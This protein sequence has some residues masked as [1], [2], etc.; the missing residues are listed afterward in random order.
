MTAIIAEIALRC[1]LRN[2][3]LNPLSKIAE[4]SA[5]TYQGI[6]AYIIKT[7]EWCNLDCSYCY[8][9]HG[10]DSSFENRPRYMPRTAVNALVPKIIDHCE[11]HGIDAV[12]INVHGGEPLLQP[13]EDY[14]WMMEQFDRIDAAGIRTYRKVTTNGVTLDDE[15]AELLA[16]IDGSR[17]L[18]D[19]ARVDLAGR[20]SYDRSVRGLR[21]ALKWADRGLEVGTISVLNPAEHGADTYHHLRSLGVESVHVLLPEMN[22]VQPPVP[23]EDGRT[24]GDVLVEFFDAWVG[25][26]NPRVDVSLFVDMAKAVAGLPSSSDQFGY[27]PVRVAVLETDGSLQPT[28]SFRACADGM[29]DLG[30]DIYRDSIDQLYNH[31]FFRLC[32]DQQAF[33]PDECRDCR[34]VD[35]CGG[36]RITS[37]Y[38]KED[39][40][41]RKSIHCDSLYRIFGHVRKTL[42]DNNLLQ[43]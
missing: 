42:D 37:R 22:Y 1:L 3:V 16:R 34:F 19:A 36:G 9:Y 11:R 30:I 21:T 6:D 41:S 20:G 43:N 4:G 13:K 8:Y 25:E 23:R 40:F 15:W 7:V 38:S 32:V 26:D 28:D 33:V 29:T 31:E 24:Y 14:R 39:G 2:G 17:D 12:V 18:H 5:M 27:A 35:I 10:Q